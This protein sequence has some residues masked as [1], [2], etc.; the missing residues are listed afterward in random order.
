[1]PACKIDGGFGSE[2]YVFLARFLT[3]FE[4][5]SRNLLLKL[6]LEYMCSIL[7]ILKI[8]SISAWFKHQTLGLQGSILPR[9][10]RR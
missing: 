4:Y 1:M 7:V 3:G 5:L 6:P 8:R 2:A 10:D 9:E